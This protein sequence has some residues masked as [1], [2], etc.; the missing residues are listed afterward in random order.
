MKHNLDALKNEVEAYLKEAGFLVFYGFSRAVDDNPEIDWDTVQHPDFRMFLDIAKQLGVKLVVLHHLQFSSAVIDRALE[1]LE[2]ESLEYE[3]QRQLEKRLREL[4]MYDGF[5]CVIELSFD[6]NGT[7]YM[8]E[9]RTEW[10]EEINEILDQ[11]DLG[12]PDDEDED[13]DSYG[14]Y[15]SKN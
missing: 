1:D 10:Y 13:D 2:D 14:G 7:M 11:M 8:F 9:L 5:T 6:H 3:D 4:K 12:M 15:Y